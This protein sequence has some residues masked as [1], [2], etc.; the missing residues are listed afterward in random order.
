MARGNRQI[1]DKQQAFVASLVN[2]AGNLTAAAREAGYAF[3]NVDAF[4]LV[5]NP[6]VVQEIIGQRTRLIEIEGGNLAYATLKECMGRENPGSV[7]VAAAK[8]VAAMAGMDRG[9]NIMADR[10]EL[11]EMTADELQSL[12]TKIDQAQDGIALGAKQIEGQATIRDD[13]AGS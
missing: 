6:A 13:S 5:R 10:K 2:G 7:R 11:Q 9:A 8:A 3:P 4:R 1:T 12:L